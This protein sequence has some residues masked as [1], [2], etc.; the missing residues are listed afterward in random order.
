MRMRRPWFSTASL[1][2][3][4]LRGLRSRSLLT[5][6][7]VLLAAI[8]VAAAVVGPMYQSA[9]AASYLVSKLRLQPDYI[10]GLTVD[11]TPTRSV[12]GTKAVRLARQPVAAAAVSR[13]LGPEQSLWSSRLVVTTKRFASQQPAKAVLAALPDCRQLVV[14]GRCPRREGEALLLAFDAR[15]T[16]TSV[17]D[18]VA[19]QGLARP[20]RVVGTYRVRS[21]DT[22]RFDDPSRFT[23][24]LPQPTPSGGIHSPYYPAP[25]V[26]APETLTALKPGRWFV[27]TDYQL[28]VDAGTTLSDVQQAIREVAELRRLKRASLIG[29]TASLESGNAL[30][31]V[32]HQVEQRRDTARQTVTPAVLSLILVA[33][34]LLGRLL[35]AAM[36]LRRPELALASLRGIGRRQLWLLGLLEPVLMLVVATPIG[37]AA[38]YVAARTLARAWLEP[39][40]P[41]SVSLT[42]IGFALGVIA[43]AT[44]IAALTVRSALGEPLSSQIAGVRRP[45]RSGRWGIVGRLA[46]VAGAAVVLAAT[47][48]SGQ[49]STP[50]ATDLVLPILLALA[51]GLLTT[52]G[53][54]KAAGWLARRSTRTRGVPGY[55]ASRTIAR[56]R[57]G[58]WAI[59]PLAAALAIAVFAAGIYATAASWRGS[60]AATQVGADT[61]YQVDVPLAQALALT[62]QIDP[63]GKWLMALSTDSDDRGLKVLVDAPRLGR[64]AVWP[65]SWTP[66]LTA[67][68]VSAALSPNR[69][70]LSLT[71]RRV[72]LSVDNAVHA[73]SPALLLT[74][75]VI[76]AS[77]QQQSVLVGP[78]PPG[79]SDRSADMPCEDGC[80]VV[81]L[82]IGG[83]GP[84]AERMHGTV[85]ISRLRADGAAVSYFGRVGWRDGN[86]DPGVYGPQAVT[87]TRVTRSVL[88]VDLETHRQDAVARLV[89][90]DNPPALPVLMGRTAAP[91]IVSRSGRDVTIA[92]SDQ[93]NV[94]VRPVATTEST[95]YFGPSALLVDA[96]MYTR[97]APLTNA[98]NTVYVL[99]RA[100][101]PASVIRALAADGIGS[102]LRLADVRRTLDQDAYA[103]ALNLYAVVTVLVILLAVAG[104]AVNMAV[105]IPARRRDAASLRVVGLRRRAIV[106][107]V[108][109]ELTAVLGAAA[110]A[111]ILAGALAQYVV[112][113]TLTLGYADET[114]TPRVLPSL[115]VPTVVVLLAVTF[116]GLLV[117]AIALGN[118]TVRGA[119]T[120]TLRETAA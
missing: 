13:F 3:T 48:W 77:G 34:V 61:S 31:P 42:S 97:A 78:F 15:H 112:V 72:Q 82:S 80:Q 62:H 30:K 118:L 89:P 86:T 96:T 58:T 29:G 26:V 117:V 100:D 52:L 64:V 17:G 71:G 1:I 56:R 55:V 53:A 98:A 7:S 87:D 39:G 2:A 119:R 66:G 59:L 113:R 36:D 102:P 50:A 90:A 116:A 5:V 88:S 101:A 60:D 41:L 45:V 99:A 84:F 120:A 33:L 6:G 105:Q 19:L 27:R 46:L 83:P 95:P 37:L 57:E 63:Q 81:G 11:Y 69:P 79:R 91:L 76:T 44:G 8:A 14:S 47:L 73:T 20:L 32:V 74:L 109:A 16:S 67:S 94:T 38:G 103:L 21:N 104:L 114:F 23:S 18:P 107:A 49:R 106:T 93:L 51:T 35:A 115:D 10:T 24:V 65:N 43:S 92:T 111:G 85:A 28:R 9:S 12:S 108:A 4:G 68:Q 75:N 110:I 70:P 25:L 54:A 22:G 40:L